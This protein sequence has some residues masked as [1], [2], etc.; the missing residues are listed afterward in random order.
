MIAVSCD[1]WSQPTLTR[2]PLSTLLFTKVV[3][4]I[5]REL[6]YEVEYNIRETKINGPA[7]ADDLVLYE[8]ST[9]NIQMLLTAAE[10]EVAKFKL[11]FRL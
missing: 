10:R 5:L 4:R 7:Y 8:F 9:E 2:R 3:D 1:E 6:P 11:E